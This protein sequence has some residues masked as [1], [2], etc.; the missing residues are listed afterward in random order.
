MQKVFKIP[1]MLRKN[2]HSVSA[3][4]YG[5]LDLSPAGKCHCHDIFLHV[6]QMRNAFAHT[7]YAR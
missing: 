7:C 1:P 3:A 2:T 5:C 4:L 6:V